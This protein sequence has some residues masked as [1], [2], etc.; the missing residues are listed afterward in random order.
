M[1]NDVTKNKEFKEKESKL[2][3]NLRQTNEIELIGDL[4]R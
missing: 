2:R 1:N 3:E 4:T